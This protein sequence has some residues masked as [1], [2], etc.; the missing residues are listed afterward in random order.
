MEAVIDY[1][2]DGAEAVH[3]E[4]DGRNNHR[5]ADDTGR[6]DGDRLG[7]AQCQH[8]KYYGSSADRNNYFTALQLGTDKNCERLTSLKLQLTPNKW[9]GI[10]ATHTAMTAPATNAPPNALTRAAAMGCADPM[11]APSR[12]D[13]TAIAESAGLPSNVTWCFCSQ[14]MQPAPADRPLK[15][16]TA[17]KQR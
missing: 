8:G 7:A 15:K 11:M 9:S 5:R 3:K 14:N 12:P 10:V 4:I 1:P 13:T 2:C 17:R 16:P 6:D